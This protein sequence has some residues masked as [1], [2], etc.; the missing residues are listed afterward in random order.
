M[1][2]PR[3]NGQEPLECEYALRDLVEALEHSDHDL[4]G[5]MVRAKP[6]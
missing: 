6:E 1:N 4:W 2:D 5:L 3:A